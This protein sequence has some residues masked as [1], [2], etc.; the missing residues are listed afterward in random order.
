MIALRKA[1]HTK[2]VQLSALLLTLLFSLTSL[3]S[4]NQPPPP[5]YVSL[6]LGIPAAALQSPVKGPLPDTTVLH[7]VITF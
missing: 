7:V 4:C 3:L 5:E 2:I 1:S 6:H